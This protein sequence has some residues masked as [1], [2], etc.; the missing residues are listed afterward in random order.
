MTTVT[1]AYAINM[2][3]MDTSGDYG[4][5]HL[6]THWRADRSIVT[7]VYT[8]QFRNLRWD[9]TYYVS[10]DPFPIDCVQRLSYYCD[11]SV[12]NLDG[13][14]VPFTSTVTREFEIA[15]GVAQL[16]KTG[17]F[18]PGGPFSTELKSVATEL[19]TSCKSL[20]RREV[21]ETRKG[22]ILNDTGYVIVK[23]ALM[24]YDYSWPMLCWVGETY[25]Y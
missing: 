5:M 4:N 21:R 17:F 10:K 6:D 20:P 8:F 2:W 3:R 15:V 14:V 12:V 7:G 11:R 19:Q 9:G 22:L 24:S 25:D 18:P 1:P 23:M 16:Q 13:T